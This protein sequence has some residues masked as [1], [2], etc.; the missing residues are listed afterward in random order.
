MAKGDLKKF[1]KKCK[2]VWKTL[3]KPNKKEFQMTAKISAIGIL[4]LGAI[5]FI[6][7]LIVGLFH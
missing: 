5:G 2:R 4:I 3:K 6:I 1:V 7:A